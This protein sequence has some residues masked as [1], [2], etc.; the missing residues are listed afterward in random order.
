MP[1]TKEYAKIS[2][3]LQLELW[4]AHEDKHISLRANADAKPV[5]R[6]FMWGKTFKRGRKGFSLVC[7]TRLPDGVKYKVT[8]VLKAYDGTPTTEKAGL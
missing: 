5:K 2:D 8:I 3:F 1:E 4:D 7:T 6:L